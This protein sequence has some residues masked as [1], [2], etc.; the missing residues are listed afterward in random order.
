[1]IRP[2]SVLEKW[3]SILCIKLRQN[4]VDYEYYNSQMRAIRQDLTVRIIRLSIQKS[5]F[6]DNI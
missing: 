2:K 4:E 6:K 3:F 5:C 1:M